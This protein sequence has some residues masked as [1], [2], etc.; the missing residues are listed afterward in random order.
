MTV[1]AGQDI[2]DRFIFTPFH[3]RSQFNGMSYGLSMAGYDV[4]VAED[5]LLFPGDFSLAST[6]EHF[7]M[8]NDVL[9]IVHDKSTWARQGLSVFNTVIEPGW[10][11]YLTLELKNQSD[12]VLKIDAGSPIAQIVL[13]QLTQEAEKPYQGKYQNQ[14]KGPVGAILEGV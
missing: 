10:N 2:R 11:G 8:P 6:V 9:G 12:N 14:R 13:H 1:L 5:L 3:E 7:N 4:R